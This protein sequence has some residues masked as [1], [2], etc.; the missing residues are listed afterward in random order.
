M[1]VP[2]STAPPVVPS[3][4]LYWLLALPMFIAA[5]SS[6]PRKLDF[7]PITAMG[8]LTV[9]EVGLI[10]AGI[11]AC[12]RYSKWLL[13]RLLPYLCFMVWVGVSTVWAPPTAGGIQNGLLYLLYGLMIIFSGT[14][15]ARNA[16]YLEQLIDRG[17]LWISSV[18][19]GFVAV[20]M[21]LGGTPKDTDEGWL[22]GPRP[23]AILGL[24]VLSRLL[25][26]WYYGDQ[27]ARIWIVLWIVAIVVSLSRT[28]TAISL[29]LVCLVVLAQMRF[30]RRRLALTLPAALG[31]VVVVVT[32]AVAWTPFHDRMF[33]G[34][35]K[36]QVGGTSINVSGRL[37][38][39]TAIIESAEEK[40]LVGKGLG[41]AQDVVTTTFAHTMSGM[42]QP[43]D[44]YLRIWH[45]LGAIGLTWFLMASFTW[46][47]LLA[48]DWYLAE[49]SGSRPASL[50]MTGLLVLVALALIE[51]T[52]NAVVYQPVMATAGLFVGAAL[53]ISVYQRNA[54]AGMR[55]MRQ[56]ARD[57]HA[58]VSR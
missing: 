18:A 26:R 16:P 58:P 22:I 6:L 5:F 13:L 47:W 2:A 52:D 41:S 37:A 11:L 12:R 39:W 21:A 43:H 30:R 40:P 23:L 36:L 53:G 48:R 54:A 32:L 31:A 15:S 8:A 42:T 34:D 10:A 44:D 4:L 20:E 33:S 29:G 35:T 50:E 46:T 25:A 51:I 14:L 1:G 19:L 55:S 7:G 45:D 57:A 3:R 49:R 9:L 28:A 24:I 38:M 27:R 17:I 56:F